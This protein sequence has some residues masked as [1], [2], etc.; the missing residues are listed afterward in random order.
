GSFDS[1]AT[2]AVDWSSFESALVP[3]GVPA[4]GWNALWANFSANVG[5]TWGDYAAMLVDNAVYLGKLGK[6]VTDI[7]KLLSFELLQADGLAPV[8]TLETANDVFARAPGI[9]LS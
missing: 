2:N 6:N 1:S 9:N 4:D 5:P 7:R 8:S 3:N